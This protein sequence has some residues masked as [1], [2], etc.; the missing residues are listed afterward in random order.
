[1]AR[2]ASSARKSAVT[3]GGKISSLGKV[4]TPSK[5]KIRTHTARKVVATPTSVKK[6][7]KS[8]SS[9]SFANKEPIK[10]QRSKISISQPKVTLNPSQ[11]LTKG[12]PKKKLVLKEIKFLQQNVGTVLQRAPLLRLIKKILRDE[13]NFETFRLSKLAADC[14]QEGVEMIMVSVLEMATMLTRHAKRKTLFPS[15]LELVMKFY[16]MFTDLK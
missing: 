13:D 1:M 4:T 6:T 16:K 7:T 15:D 14:I 12:A 11:K 3:P 10:I 8:T 9:S 2:K 5:K